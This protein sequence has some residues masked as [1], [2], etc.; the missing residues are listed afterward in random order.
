M[1]LQIGGVCRFAVSLQTCQT[2]Y[3]HC[4]P[5]RQWL[6]HCGLVGLLLPVIVTMQK[7]CCTMG[8]NGNSVIRGLPSRSSYSA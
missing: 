6:N 4:K 1:L 5:V 8:S 7:A 2:G 3:S